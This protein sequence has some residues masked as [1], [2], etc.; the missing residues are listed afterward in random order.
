MICN[1]SDHIGLHLRQM[2][3]SYKIRSQAKLSLPHSMNHYQSD[4]VLHENK[5]VLLDNFFEVDTTYH[6]NLYPQTNIGMA[7][8]W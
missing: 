5:P 6:K 7:F 4:L 8:V 3:P 2:F 1:E